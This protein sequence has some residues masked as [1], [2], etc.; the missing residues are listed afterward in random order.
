MR[1]KG[2]RIKKGWSLLELSLLVGVS[3]QTISN[4]ERGKNE[5]NIENII[6]LANI[7]NVSIDYLLGR[8]DNESNL[9][10]IFMNDE[11]MD[12][13]ELRKIVLDYLKDVKIK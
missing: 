13:D 6:K 5:P 8:T 3:D 11:Y 1:L 7:F 10:S 4:W 2:L 9:D 12:A